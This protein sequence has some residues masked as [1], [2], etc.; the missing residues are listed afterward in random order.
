MSKFVVITSHALDQALMNSAFSEGTMLPKEENGVF[1]FDLSEG[2]IGFRCGTEP[3]T[4]HFALISIDCIE[5]LYLSGVKLADAYRRIARVVSSMQSPP[6]HL[7]RQWSEYH[8][9]NL[10][11][12]FAASKDVASYRW[13]SEIES[14]YKAVKFDFL[15]ADSSE[16]FL[17]KFTPEPWP[18]DFADLL[19]NLISHEV[20]RDGDKHEGLASEVDLT[21]IGSKSIVQGLTFEAW[22][23]R[24]SPLQIEVLDEVI[25]K[26]IRIVGPAGSG[27]TLALCMRALRI[28]RERSVISEGKK[29]LIATQSWAMSERIDGILVD[30]NGG[31]FPSHITV[32]PLLSLLDAHVGGI[33]QRRIDVIGDDSSDGRRK[34]ISMLHSILDD[35][36]HIQ[37]PGVSDWIL[38]GIRGKAD[39]RARLDLV[40][41]LYEEMTGILSATG[42]SPDDGESVKFYLNGARED[43]MPPFRL[44]DERVFV[45][46]IYERLLRELIDR[47]AITTDQFVLDS[48]RVLETFNWRMRKETEGYDFIFVDELQL[49]DPQERA[50]LE[51]LAR[52]K[53]GVPFV[54]AEDPSQGVFS[55]L[56]GRHNTPAD[57]TVYLD[58]VHRFNRDIF[59]FISFIYRK[60]PLNAIPLRTNEGPS[61]ASKRPVV[62]IC[63]RMEDSLDF[64]VDTAEKSSSEVKGSGRIC[65][66]TLGDC[67]A[68]ITAKLIDRGLSATRLSGFD[69]V[70]QLAYSRKSIVVSPWEYVGGTQFSSVIVVTSGISSPASQF[71]RLREM[72]SVY[73]SCSRAR[74]QL[75]IVCDSYVPSVLLEAAELGLVV[76]KNYVDD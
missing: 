51:L 18:Q 37:S 28:A 61:D 19:Q 66:A 40:G 7:P 64:A 4:P 69:D 9:K 63:D 38:D 44:F 20:K 30:L 70:E 8:F 13:V 23:E 36:S 42:V 68:E 6:V 59:E 46:G 55:S 67:D 2:I 34:M 27:K 72:I 33:G 22:R 41:Y 62:V 60:F 17:Q 49:F 10:I 53:Q 76:K 65:V 29:V 54:T 52:S 35:S 57:E 31:V 25:E 39:G 48:I 14:R 32:Y 26:S 71:S 73:L 56:N 74:D 45:F 12:F 21:V 11:A 1:R 15:S 43:W 47:E 5:T 58:T 75:V 16:V 3:G 24:L 50:A